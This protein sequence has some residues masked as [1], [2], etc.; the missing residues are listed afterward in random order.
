MGRQ[1]EAE[2][3]SSNKRGRGQGREEQREPSGNLVIATAMVATFGGRCNAPIMMMNHRK[4][5]RN[6]T[7]CSL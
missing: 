3:A 5:H 1:V 4:N 7:K 2:V 6:V